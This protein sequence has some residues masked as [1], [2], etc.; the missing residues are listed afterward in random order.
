MKNLTTLIRCD[1]EF[2]RFLDTLKSSCK[3]S[4]PLPIAVNGLSG[5]AEFAFLAESIIE[6]KRTSGASVLV[7]VEGESEREGL[8]TR[9]ADIGIRAKQYKKRD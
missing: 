6:A 5:G 3:E 9:L 4:S 2:T 8:A 1:A 7:L